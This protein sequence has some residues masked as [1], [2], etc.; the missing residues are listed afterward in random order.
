MRNSELRK[1][2]HED[3]SSFRIPNS[4]FPIPFTPFITT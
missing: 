1:A 2:F 3:N 4:E